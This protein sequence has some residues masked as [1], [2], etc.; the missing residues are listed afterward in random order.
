MMA[1]QQTL[2]AIQSVGYDP[3]AFF[4]SRPGVSYRRLVRDLPFPISP[5]ELQWAHAALSQRLGARAVALDSLLRILREHLSGGWNASKSEN[6]ATERTAF[7]FWRNM[8]RYPEMVLWAEASERAESFLF[9]NLPPDNW[10]P[11]DVR[12]PIL[13]RTI[14]AGFDTPVRPAPNG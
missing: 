9:S 10:K 14:H 3:V 2:A 4:G 12:D 13:E 11:V 1:A 5:A 6:F 8:F 7:L